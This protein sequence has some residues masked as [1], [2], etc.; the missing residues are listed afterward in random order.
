MF[1]VYARASLLTYQL[2]T[3]IILFLEAV[4]GVVDENEVFNDI[5]GKDNNCLQLSFLLKKLFF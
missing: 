3:R 5:N 1:F 4:Q 2:R